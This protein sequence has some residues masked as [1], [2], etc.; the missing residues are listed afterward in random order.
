[1]CFVRHK[2]LEIKPENYFVSVK[3]LDSGEVFVQ[4]YDKLIIATG[5]RPIVPPL[6]GISARNVQLLRTVPDA[7]QLKHLLVSGKAKKAVVIGGG[8]IGLEAVENLRRQGVAVTLVEK[9]DQVMP[10]LD[11]EMTVDIEKELRQM[12]VRVILGNGI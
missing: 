11:R 1:M 6:E 10:P 4:P 7:E 9:T 8:F 12:G 5:A 3:N 2:V